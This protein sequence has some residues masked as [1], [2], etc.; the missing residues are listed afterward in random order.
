MK[1]IHSHWCPMYISKYVE[2][3]K[4]KE[5]KKVDNTGWPKI[6]LIE[7]LQKEAIKRK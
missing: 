4:I 2:P 6:E 5:E 7:R 3:E 1:Q